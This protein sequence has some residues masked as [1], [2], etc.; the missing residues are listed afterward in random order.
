MCHRDRDQ[1]EQDHRTRNHQRTRTSTGSEDSSFQNMLQSA[2]T[3]AMSSA[4]SVLAAAGHG[5]SSMR[6]SGEVAGP[7]G[8]RVGIRSQPY[9]SDASTHARYVKLHYMSS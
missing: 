6:R 8:I 2:I 7:S 1:Q 9:N 3:G 5:E 4:M